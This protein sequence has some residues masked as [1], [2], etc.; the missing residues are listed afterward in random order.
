[1]EM[2]SKEWRT[3]MENLEFCDV[4]APPR[5]AWGVPGDSGTLFYALFRMAFLELVRLQGVTKGCKEAWVKANAKG[6]KV[7]LSL[8]LGTFFFRSKNEQSR[9][10]CP[11]GSLFL[12]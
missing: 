7:A 1:M 9:K 2:Y 3:E 8:G 4:L 10:N 12:K 5:G 11:G 6:I